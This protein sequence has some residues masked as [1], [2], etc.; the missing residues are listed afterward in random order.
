MITIKIILILVIKKVLIDKQQS[1]MDFS[2]KLIYNKYLYIRNLIY[3][4]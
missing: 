2:N 1:E 4:D 3:N